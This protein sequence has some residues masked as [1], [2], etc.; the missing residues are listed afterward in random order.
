MSPPRLSLSFSGGAGGD[1][2]GTGGCLGA[3]APLLLLGTVFS[4][5]EAE[6]VTFLVQHHPS[7]APFNHNLN[8]DLNSQF[9]LWPSLSLQQHILKEHRFRKITASTLPVVV[10]NTKPKE[11]QPPRNECQN[12]HLYLRER[13]VRKKLN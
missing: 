10:Q 5:K 1:G 8:G 4:E 11:E 2:C 3:V 13:S 6:R 12:L 9:V 7:P